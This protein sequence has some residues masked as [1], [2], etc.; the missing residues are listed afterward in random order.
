MMRKRLMAGNWKMFKLIAELEPFF[1]TFTKELKLDED[2]GLTERVGMAFAVPFTQL[3]RAAEL[4][5]PLG[6]R[7][8]AQNV[9]WQ[10]EGAFTG[11]V[12]LAMLR[13][14]GIATT[15]I[16]HSERRQFAGETDDTVARKTKAALAAGFLPIVCVG[17]TLAERDAGTTADVVARQLGAVL[18]AVQGDSLAARELVIAYEPVW[19]IGTGRAATAAQA[20]EVHGLIRRQVVATWGAQAAASL[21]IL[22]GGSANP[23]NIRELLDQSDIDGALVGGASLKPL[24][25]AQMVRVALEA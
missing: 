13:E 5:K 11:E 3:A 16:G 6:V 19:A 12:S 25:F 7:I 2:R 9:H 10:A 22:Y 8:A 1:E 18:A 20:Q 17:E 4:A 21:R 14:V 15:L 24:D 23:G